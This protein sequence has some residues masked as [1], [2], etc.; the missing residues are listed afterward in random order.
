VG[1]LLVVAGF[2]LD[3]GAGGGV[4][5]LVLEREEGVAFAVAGSGGELGDGERRQNERGKEGVEVDG[6]AGEVEAGETVVG[7]VV[8]EACESV[9]AG[10]LDFAD[11]AEGVDE[12]VGGDVGEACLV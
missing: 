6:E 7:V 2:E 4:D 8:N 5:V 11:E 3:V 12:L 10:T 9:V 1:G